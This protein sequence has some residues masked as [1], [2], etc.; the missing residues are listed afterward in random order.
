MKFKKI[1]IK[2][3]SKPFGRLQARRAKKYGAKA[4][5]NKPAL[6]LI[7]E[8]QNESDDNTV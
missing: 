8:E 2:R 6:H 7:K 5:P 1:Y 4:E 3:I